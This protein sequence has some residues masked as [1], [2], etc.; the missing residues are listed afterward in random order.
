[1]SRAPTTY[2]WE[3]VLDPGREEELVATARE[4]EQAGLPEPIPEDLHPA[5]REGL[6]YV[7][8]QLSPEQS[9][10]NLADEIMSR[11]T[12]P[13]PAGSSKET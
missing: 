13:L 9:V 2:P 6:A 5:L 7:R 4:R 1:M 11:L 12:A 8:E 10:A 3:A